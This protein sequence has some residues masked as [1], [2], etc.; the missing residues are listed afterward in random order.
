[1]DFDLYVVILRMIFL[2]ESPGGQNSPTGTPPAQRDIQRLSDER[3]R[4]RDVD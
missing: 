3:D 2:T 4:H 1:M